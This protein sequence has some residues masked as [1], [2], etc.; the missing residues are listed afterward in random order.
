VNTEDALVLLVRRDGVAPLR[1]IISALPSRETLANTELVGEEVPS[2]TNCM[3]APAHWKNWPVPSN[4][5]KA[6]LLAKLIIPM[7]TI[8]NAF[9]FA[10]KLK[11]TPSI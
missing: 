9:V 1:I 3:W 10:V 2:K 11:V 8:L 4:H 7:F 6:P 5:L